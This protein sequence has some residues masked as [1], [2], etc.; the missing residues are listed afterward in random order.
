MALSASR[1]KVG[2]P[3]QIVGR[4]QSRKYIKRYPDHEKEMVAYEVSVVQLFDSEDK[5]N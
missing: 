4:M 2:D 1:K 3:V 5:A